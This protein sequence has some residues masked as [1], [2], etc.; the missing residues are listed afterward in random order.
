MKRSSVWIL[1]HCGFS[2]DL[3]EFEFIPYSDYRGIDVDKMT[4]HLLFQIR[5]TILVEYWWSRAFRRLYKSIYP[6]FYF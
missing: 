4:V 5:S 2:K 3:I 6:E 1:S